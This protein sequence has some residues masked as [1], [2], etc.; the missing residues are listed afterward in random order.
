M[1]RF[2]VFTTS[3][4]D[5]PHWIPNKYKAIS[6]FYTITLLL[7]N[8]F[9]DF[10]AIFPIVFAHFMHFHHVIFRLYFLHLAKQFQ[11]LLH[12]K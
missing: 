3:L 2:A 8:N 9:C 5:K 12:E 4:K 6:K 11:V 1:K 7:L 10:D